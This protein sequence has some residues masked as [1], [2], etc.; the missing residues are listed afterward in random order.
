M[1]LALTRVFAVLVIEADRCVLGTRPNVRVRDDVNIARIELILTA[2]RFVIAV[3]CRA[4]PVGDRRP[5]VAFR[6]RA[7]LALRLLLHLNLSQVLQHR[8]ISVVLAVLVLK[9]D[10]LVFGTRQHVLC[11]AVIDKVLAAAGLVITVMCRALSVRDRLRTRP[12][13]GVRLRVPPRLRCLHCCT[14]L[15]YGDLLRV[16][17]ETLT[18]LLLLC[19]SCRFPVPFLCFLFPCL[20]A[21]LLDP[22]RFFLGLLFLFLDPL[23]LLLSSL[24]LLSGVFER[25]ALSFLTL[26]V[27]FGPV[28]YPLVLVLGDLC[29]DS[30]R[31]F[32][33]FRCGA[34][35]GR[36]WPGLC[37]VL[38]LAPVSDAVSQHHSRTTWRKAIGRVLL[39]L[40]VPWPLPRG[41]GLLFRLRQVPVRKP[42]FCRHA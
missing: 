23:N 35:S 20:F 13:V 1:R 2:A 17:S 21:V 9:A 39:V 11:F 15:I 32:D 33:D 16:V 24:S 36:K 18:R 7:S 27:A 41:V 38:L 14:L 4:L 34:N 12:H 22:L 25:L 3:M 31:V 29:D 28:R 40:R 8:A 42:E 19:G 37:C 30:G 10:R 5:S 6:A 26:Q